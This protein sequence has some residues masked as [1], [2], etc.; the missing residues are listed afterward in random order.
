MLAAGYN[1][2]Y[3]PIEGLEGFRKATLQLLLGATHAA[4]KDNRVAVVQVCMRAV[5]LLLH[6]EQAQQP[7]SACRQHVHTYMHSPVH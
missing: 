6:T 1:K 3:L 2:E 5:M 7:F 4:I